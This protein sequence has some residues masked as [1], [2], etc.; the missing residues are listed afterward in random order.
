MYA[1][2]RGQRTRANAVKSN[3]DKRTQLKE[4]QVQSKCEC[5]NKCKKARDHRGA[6]PA[7]AKNTRVD[8]KTKDRSH[9]WAEVPATFNPVADEGKVANPATDEKRAYSKPLKGVDRYSQIAAGSV[10]STDRGAEPSPHL[11]D[12]TRVGGEVI[13]QACNEVRLCAR[14]AEPIVL[15]YGLELVHR[16]SAHGAVF[17]P[18]AWLCHLLHP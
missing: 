7:H 4:M 16:H 8:R 13:P 1:R 9:S 2:R 15:G 17:G 12:L 6:E 10:A 14:R 18:N 11:R 5:E 3:K